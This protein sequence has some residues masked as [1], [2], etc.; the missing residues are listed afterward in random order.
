M[1]LAIAFGVQAQSRD[2]LETEVTAD[3]DVILLKWS[4]KHAWDADLQTAPPILLAEYRAANG[5]V[6]VDC[7]RAGPAAAPQPA[8]RGGFQRGVGTCGVQGV[9]RGKADDRTVS[10]R[11]P[12]ILTT[13][14]TGP[15]CLYFQL[16]NQR[17]LPLRLSNQRGDSTSR[18]RHEDWDRELTRRTSAR[19]LQQTVAA[20]QRN[21]A[22]LTA[23]VDQLR[24]DNTRKNWTSTASCAAIPPPVFQ[25]AGADEHPLAAPAEREAIARQVCV[26]QVSNADKLLEA[27]NYK[28]LQRLTVGL[29]LP[30]GELQEMLD[31]LEGS[32]ERLPPLFQTRKAELAQ[33]LRDWQRLAPQVPGYRAALQAR[34]LRRPHF[35]EYDSMIS[36]QSLA[37]GIGKRI[38]EGAVSGGVNA[39]DLL[40]FV[41]GSLEA[42]NRCRADGIAQMET[43]YTTETQLKQQE[44]ILLKRAH[45]QLIQACTNGIATLDREQAKL[46]AEQAR[47][48]QAEQT[49]RDATA[50]PFGPIARRSKDLNSVACAP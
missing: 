43:A 11:L 9:A 2:T 36:L 34:R 5:T 40:G 41:G 32:G 44:P 33:Y 10:Y 6:G 46:V 18:F 20:L 19:D 13:A 8:V 31:S 48:A 16:P 49:L 7:L 23:N 22:V 45:D 42:Y 25:A 39:S 1:A 50:T 27:R 4:K 35:G 38:A 28:D 47:A 12:E 21:V 15:V 26:M 24:A 14:P 30:P 37:E 3:G 29:V 17:I